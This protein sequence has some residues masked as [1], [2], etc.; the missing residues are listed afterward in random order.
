MK[1]RFLSLSLIILIYCRPVQSQVYYELD[2]C[3]AISLERNFS[4]LIARNNESIAANNY[5]LGN[6][7][8]LPSVDFT[9]RYNGT[10][11]NT[12]QNL[13]D[14][15]QNTSRGV[16]NTT[17]NAGVALGWTIFNGFNV[18]TTY[19][20]LNELKLLGALNTQ[21][22]IENLV[23]DV[24]SAYYAYILQVQRLKNSRYAVALSRERLRIDEARYLLGSSSKLQVLQS[25]VY[26][27]AD[28][29]MASRQ[30]ETVIE[31]QIRLNEMMAIE[32]L[33]QEFQSKDTIID[34]NTELLYERL[35]SETMEK[36]T[37][38]A[39]ASKN[40]IISEKDYK[41]AVS[42][43]Y[44]YLNLS[45]GYNY[46]YNTFSSGANTSQSTNG[47]NYGLTFGVNI[48]DGFNQKRNIRN[49]SI[50]VENNDLNLLRVDQG[51]KADL[52]AMYSAYANNL[53]L[54]SL[55]D[56]N[57]LTATENLEIAQESYKL[58]SLSGLELREVQKSLLDAVERLISI[59]YQTKLAEISLM[60][61]S[62]GI[63]EY[64]R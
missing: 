26:L 45:S 40:K 33:A 25:R 17:T 55:E 29:S 35:L 22:S 20:K 19:Q 11:N 16:N 62:G 5:S 53:R 56:Q 38:L 23:A 18:Q 61:I 27:N 34:L 9:G 12:T 60:L 64:Y 37:S 41:L 10:I 47:L 52:L 21:M 6:A 30:L 2:E 4:I 15:S 44:P 51:V 43:S 1:V 3:I 36:N 32:N 24:V 28:S 63:M 59:Q 13:A 31:A 42:R 46:N 57:L 54:I 49:S 14:G 8:Y 50:N 7:G 58:G 48:F 39:I